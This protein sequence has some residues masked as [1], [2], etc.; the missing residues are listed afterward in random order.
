VAAA[1]REV[2]RTLDLAPNFEKAQA[3]LL[4]LQEKRP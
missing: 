1:R 2:L 3:L 4:S